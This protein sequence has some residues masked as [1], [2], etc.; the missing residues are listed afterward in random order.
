LIC[1][2]FCRAR[3]VDIV[4]VTSS[5]LVAPTIQ[6]FDCANKFAYDFQANFDPFVQGEAG[7]ASPLV[8]A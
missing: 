6:L 7:E 3:F 5:I 1:Y 8:S 4:G 2:V